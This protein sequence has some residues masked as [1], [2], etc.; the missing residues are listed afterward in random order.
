MSRQSDNQT[1]HVAPKYLPHALESTLSSADSEQYELVTTEARTHATA[2]ISIKTNEQTEF[3][4]VV[5]FRLNGESYGIEARYVYEVMQLPHIT[6]VPHTP[7]FLKGVINLRGEIL[8]VFDFSRLFG[9]GSSTVE[10]TAQLIIFGECHPHCAFV[11]DVVDEVK[12]VYASALSSPVA[13]FASIRSEM[14][15]GVTAEALVIL[16]GRELLTDKRLIIEQ[17][18]DNADE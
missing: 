15:R 4:E 9:L 2:G 1:W 12:T 6:V 5:T 11:V 13:P 3:L 16:D 14:V 10:N 7:A 18:D 8:A 17:R